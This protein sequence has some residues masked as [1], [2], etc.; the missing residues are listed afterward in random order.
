MLK[1]LFA[2]V[3]CIFMATNVVKIVVDFITARKCK[4]AYEQISKTM[5]G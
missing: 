5:K 3:L 4:K 1:V 2:L